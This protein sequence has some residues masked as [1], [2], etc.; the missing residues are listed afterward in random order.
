MKDS[1]IRWVAAFALLAVIAVAAIF[2]VDDDEVSSEAIEEKFQALEN[3]TS[4]VDENHTLLDQDGNSNPKRD[5][6]KEKFDRRDGLKKK[7]SKGKFDRAGRGGKS[8]KGKPGMSKPLPPMMGE[9]DGGH[10][11]SHDRHMPPMMGEGFMPPMMGMMG[12][13]FMPPMMGMMGEGFMPPMMGEFGPTGLG[14]GFMP[15]MM[16]MM[17]EGFERRESEIFKEIQQIFDSIL[18]SLESIEKSD[19]VGSKATD[20]EISQSGELTLSL[21]E[22]LIK[23]TF[24]QRFEDEISELVD[25]VAK[26]A[27]T[28]IIEGLNQESYEQSLEGT[29]ESN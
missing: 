23:E 19:S 14:E 20:E 17:G 16:G 11:G 22:E 9:M 28:Q 10:W 27:V 21:I 15:P 7:K 5:F 13:G 6:K 12:E 18:D 1:I 3:E 8:K 2:V 26:D 4:S 29:T 25:R 24:D